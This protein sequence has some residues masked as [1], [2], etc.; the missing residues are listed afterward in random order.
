MG[1][2]TKSQL[3][4]SADFLGS[5]LTLLQKQCALDLDVTNGMVSHSPAGGRW[6]AAPASDPS[7]S[8]HLGNLL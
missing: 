4:M 5:V 6:G 2:N 7:Q 3:A 1:D 8:P